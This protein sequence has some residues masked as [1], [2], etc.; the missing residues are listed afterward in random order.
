MYDLNRKI[1]T[2]KQCHLPAS[3]DYR[4]VY[5]LTNEVREKLSRVQP[6]TLGQA[7]RIAGVTPAALMALQIHLKRIKE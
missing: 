3:L 6:L 2:G 1:V 7:G 5:G 4:T